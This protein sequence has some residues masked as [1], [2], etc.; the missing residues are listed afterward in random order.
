MIGRREFLSAIAAAFLFAALNASGVASAQS[1][2]GNLDIYW[3]DTEGGAA[4]LVITPT[5]ESMLFD[6]GY[7]DDDRDAKRIVAAARE[8]GI[9]RID[10]LV[11]SHYHRDHVGG[12]AALTKLIPIGRYYGPN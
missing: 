10:H 8:A 9:S 6:T 12:L 1:K 7:P 3:I 11:I 5:G 2:S 4:T